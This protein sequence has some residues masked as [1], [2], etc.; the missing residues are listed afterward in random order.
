MTPRRDAKWWGWGDP[1][2]E[3]KLDDEALGVLR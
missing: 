3:P 2:V 1:A